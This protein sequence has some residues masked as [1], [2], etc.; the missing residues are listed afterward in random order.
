MTRGLRNRGTTQLKRWLRDRLPPIADRDRRI[1]EHQTS[2][3]RLRAEADQLRRD[4]AARNLELHAARTSPA[5]EGPIADH[6][7]F[8]NLLLALRHQ[9]AV[10]VRRDGAATTP[11]M[12]VP[13]KLRNYRLA[14]SHGVAV[15][16][17]LTVW[18]SIDAIDCLERLPDR[19]VLKSDG[20]AGSSGVFLLERTGSARYTPLG[21]TRSIS[22]SE[23][24]KHLARLDPRRVRPPFF[25]ERYLDVVPS[26]SEIPEDVKIYASYGRIL[27]VMVRRVGRHGAPSTISTRFLDA[28]GSDLGPVALDRRGDQTIPVP[29]SLAAMVEVA[30][31][32]S[33]AVGLSFCRVDLYDG[34]HGP[35]LGEITRAPGGSQR[36]VEDHDR[37]LGEQWLRGAMELSRDLSLGRPYGVLHGGEDAP[38]L[39]PTGHVSRTQDAG[40]WTPRVVPCGQWC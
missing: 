5:T 11:L 21:S 3:R 4:L 19:F 1:V 27:Q 6:P 2:I 8:N 35:V 24:K 13:Y 34:V 7:S 23:L 29:R 33:R 36:Y 10:A 31:H 22:E 30:R 39:Y 18:E 38:N 17:V 14:S 16:E 12:Q 15:P 37:W 9:V 32:L 20:G 26:S 25:A 40:A 28:H